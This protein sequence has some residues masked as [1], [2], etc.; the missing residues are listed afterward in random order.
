MRI[1]DGDV[2]EDLV[3]LAA[4]SCSSRPLISRNP[5]GVAWF[6]DLLRRT[7]ALGYD[8][9]M[10]DFGEYVRATPWRFATA[11]AATKLHNA[12]PVL[13]AQGRARSSREGEARTISCSSCAPATRGTQRWVP[14][15]WS[16]DAEATFDE[17]QGLPSVLRGGLNLG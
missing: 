8:G 14:A 1:E 5:D 4:S 13:S 10:H 17:T 6:Q 15:V 3:H 2:A 9:W 11:G 12:F 16:G 7:L